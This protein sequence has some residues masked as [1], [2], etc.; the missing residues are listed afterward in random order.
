MATLLE[1]HQL[2]GDGDMIHLVEAA[3]VKKAAA[4]LEEATPSA[5]RLDFARSACSNPKDYGDVLWRFLVGTYSDQ[6]Q[7]AISRSIGSAATPSDATI[8]TAVN[9]AIDKLWP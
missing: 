7:D 9:T 4:I 1:L 8:E 6:T 2:F 3:I 5:A